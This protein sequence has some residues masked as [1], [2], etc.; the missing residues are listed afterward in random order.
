MLSGLS[1][2]AVL[3]KARGMH[4]KCLTKQNFSDLLMCK[5]ISEI[6]YYLKNRTHYNGV[7]SNVNEIDVSRSELEVVLKQKLFEDC[8][9]LGKYGASVGERFSD[10]LMRRSEIEQIMHSLILINSGRADGYT[11]YMPEY[12]QK[13]T[14]INVEALG[15]MKTFDDLLKALDHTPYQKL[16]EPFRPGPGELLDY[17]KVEN[18]LYT[19]LYSE[20]FAMINKHYKGSAAKQLREIFSSY[21]DLD[22]YVRIVRMKTYYHA[23]PEAIREALLPFSTIRKSFLED[24]INA[25]SEEEIQAIM[26]KTSPG[27]RY[28]KGGETLEDDIP[29]RVQYATCRHDIHFSTHSSVVMLS[30]IFIKQAEIYDIIN[31]IEGVRY[32]LPASRVSKLL[33]IFNF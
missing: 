2:N 14:H 17:T 13:K 21:L 28:L 5:S 25:K 10:Y 33:T 8:S 24:M 32:Q 29:L 31:I 16:V 18:A 3:A 20:V 15:Q 12:L 30:Y 6:A 1:A 7:L 26:A 23:P 9:A 22:N 4:G 11:L 19:Y 27:K